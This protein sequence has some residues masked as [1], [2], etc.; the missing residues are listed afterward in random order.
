MYVDNNN[1]DGNN[2]NSRTGVSTY[3]YTKL[4]FYGGHPIKVMDVYVYIYIQSTQVVHAYY[5]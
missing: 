5:F 2:S 3:S 4:H 1:N